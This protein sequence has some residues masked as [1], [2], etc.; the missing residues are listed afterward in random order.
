MAKLV[1]SGKQH[2]KMSI[3]NPHA[4]GIDIGSRFHVVSIGQGAD[5]VKTFGVFT[6]DLTQLCA[7]LSHHG[8]RT[9]AMESTGYYWKPLFV[10]LQNLGF[11]V[12]LVNAKHIK[13]AKGVKTDPHDSRRLQKLHSLGLLTAS[14]QADEEV[15]VLR[16]YCRH[17]RY[18]VAQKSRYVNRM[19]KCLTLMNI[20]LGIVLSD[21]DSLSGLAI[22][23][24]II[25]GQRDVKHLASLVN[26]QVKASQ[27]TLERSLQ[28]T[29]RKECL[30]ELEQ[31]VVLYDMYTQR[32][33]DCDAEIEKVLT[34]SVAV[35][36]EGEVP[37]LPE[38]TKLT[39]KKKAKNDPN[40]DIVKL[41]ALLTNGIDLLAIPGFGQGS[42]LTVLSEVGWELD[43][44]F[45]SS[46]HFT[47]WLGLAPNVQKSGGKVLSSRTK[48]NKS[49]AAQAFRQAANS[50]G[51]MKSHPL[52]S[53]FRRIAMRKDRLA[54]IVATARKLAAIY[55]NM[56]TKTEDFKY[57]PNEE[58]EKRMRQNQLLKIKK[59]INQHDF[60]LDELGLAA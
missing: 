40:F 26:R 32:I 54:A 16:S 3:I 4:A 29:W 10:M 44:K 22:V 36:H 34:Q 53:F 20:Q 41:S 15:E 11:E 49:I 31:C 19:Y 18:I 57:V 45:E 46:K 51:N 30:F 13:D 38:G 17:R 14:Y 8:V 33:K 59:L 60:N 43:K 6:D 23:R 56:V 5:D 42:L 48:K 2:M 25:S 58:Y 50:V 27:E 35:R 12:Y 1:K 24:A 21:I 47:S 37:V 9:V 52:N 7:Y 55:Y 28:G 39:R